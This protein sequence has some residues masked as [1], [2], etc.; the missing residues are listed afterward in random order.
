MTERFFVTQL[1]RLCKS[2]LKS[3]PAAKQSVSDVYVMQSD[4]GT[5]FVNTLEMAAMC[6]TF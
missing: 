3:P 6:L 5:F 2:D 4:D 1:V